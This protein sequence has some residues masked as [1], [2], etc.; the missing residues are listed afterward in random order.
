MVCG[1]HDLE[2]S[3]RSYAN[4]LMEGKRQNDNCNAAALWKAAHQVAR[5]WR[6]LILFQMLTLGYFLQWS[7]G[8][9]RAVAVR[10]WDGSFCRGRGFSVLLYSFDREGG[11]VGREKELI[12]PFWFWL[13]FFSPTV[14]VYDS[15]L[16]SGASDI[17]F[18]LMLRSVLLLLLLLLLLLWLLLLTLSLLLLLFCCCFVVVLLL[19]CC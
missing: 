16:V 5:T 12:R 11:A 3:Q 14:P 19:L 8:T 4:A 10:G 1:R 13:Q 17:L 18:W 2:T 15:S 7:I 9:V 6:C